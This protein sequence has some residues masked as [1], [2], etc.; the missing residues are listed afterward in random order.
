MISEN[1]VISDLSKAYKLDEINSQNYYKPNYVANT[2]FYL[3]PIKASDDKKNHSD[4]Y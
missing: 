2:V 1:N 3:P 4:F